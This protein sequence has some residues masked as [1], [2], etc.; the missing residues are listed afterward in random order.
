MAIKLLD[1]LSEIPFSSSSLPFLKIVPI[2]KLLDFHSKL[3]VNLSFLFSLEVLITMNTLCH[4]FF[5]IL[6]VM[7]KESFCLSNVLHICFSSSVVYQSSSLSS[8]LPCLKYFQCVMICNI[9]FCFFSE[10]EKS[11]IGF[12]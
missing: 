8:S 1:F 12:E 10:L 4:P 5:M 11:A 6:E 9:L 3:L 2:I 7:K